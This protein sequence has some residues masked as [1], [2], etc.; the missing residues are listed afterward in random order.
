MRALLISSF[1][2]RSR[3]LRLLAFAGTLFAWAE[4]GFAAVADRPNLVFL[5]ADDLATRGVGCYGNPEVHTPQLDRLASEGMRFARH[6]NTSAICMASRCS[7]LTG[8][9]EYRHGCNFQLGDLP[10]RMLEQSY[11]V[12]LREAGYFT[13]FAGKIGFVLDGEPF[14]AL[15]A[16]FDRWA[17]GPGQTFYETEKN[18]GIARYAA[19]Y[20]HCSRAYGAWAAD[21]VHEA[22]RRNQPF[23]LSI[24]FKAPHLPFTPDPQDLPRYEGRTF[25]RPANYGVGKGRHLAAQAHTSRAAIAYR[26]WINDYD[27]SAA[28]YYALITGMD[29]AVGM[30]REALVR[31][32]LAEN[33]VIVF[34]ADNGYNAGSHGFGDKVLPYEEASTAPLIVYDPRQP[35]HLAGQVCTAVTAGVDVAATLFDLAG[36][37]PPPGIDGRSFRPFLADPRAGGREFLPLFNFWGIQSAHSLAVV[38]RDW[39]YVR[40]HYAGDGLRPAEELFHLAQDRGE[41]RNVAGE[42]EHRVPLETMR[43]AFDAEVARMKQNVIAGRAYEVFP[44]LFDRTLAWEKKAPL[45]AKLPAPDPAA[46]GATKKGKAARK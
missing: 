26:E 9:Y 17:G 42:A 31:E 34:S 7:V 40:W 24:S 46:T 32:G 19:E 30:I 37:P 20:P 14:D 10:R 11:P 28:L 39:K 23:C 41:M 25:A 6:Y 44:T 27:R 38:A 21:F 13:G 36:V 15:A 8:L 4:P 12:R 5:F 22:K 35:A 16:F 33:T 2:L 18:P 3:R 29:A 1:T 43:R 45:L